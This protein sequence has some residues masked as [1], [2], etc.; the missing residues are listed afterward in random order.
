[1]R[2]ASRCQTAAGSAPSWLLYL[3][4][5]R[6]SRSATDGVVKTASTKAPF[7][8][9]TATD[10][11]PGVPCQISKSKAQ[12]HHEISPFGRMTASS[13]V[14]ALGRLPLPFPR[15]AESRQFSQSDLHTF[16]SPRGRPT[17]LRGKFR[18]Q[19][20]PVVYLYV[21]VSGSARQSHAHK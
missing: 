3:L 14:F 5:R 4:S 19:A 9:T 17:K 20:A 21:L 16:M 7:Y 13:Q 6:P 15:R 11:A 1:M 18:F 8:A 2:S 12:A 10:R